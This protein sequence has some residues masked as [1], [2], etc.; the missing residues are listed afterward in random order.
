M[1]IQVT[2]LG[3]GHMGTSIGLALGEHKDLVRR[4]GNDAEPNIAKR[5][6]KMGAVDQVVYNLP[7][8]VRQAD[9]V[10]LAL[11]VDE[12]HEVLKIIST[13]LKEGAVI[14]DVSTAKE[15]AA[16]WAAELLPPDRYFVAWT[17]AINPSYLLDTN[18]GIGAAHADLFQNCLIFIT[19][20]PGTAA[21]AIK[22]ASD[23]T[24]LV[25]GKP[26]FADQAEVDGLLAASSLL[27]ELTAAAMIHAVMDQPGWAEGRKLA[28][29]QFAL[30]TA[31]ILGFD[32]EQAI[33]PAA[34]E[35]SENVVRMIDNLIASLTS[36]RIAIKNKDTAGLQTQVQGAQEDRE[37]WIGERKINDWASIDSPPSG[38]PTPGDVL[39]RL[40]GFRPKPA[41]KDK[42]K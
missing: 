18:S 24:T 31:P 19:T 15:A 5:A 34:L 10:I 29:R 13:D 9:L 21:A 42:K 6:E 36:L 8:A 33:A 16:R 38:L 25:G 26:F 4:I 7:S 14:I 22:L 39:G 28:G 23:L 35:N 41:P 11:P 32:G 37:N 40:V 2:I 12:M 30:A 3:L 1:T 17:P 27:P 20:P